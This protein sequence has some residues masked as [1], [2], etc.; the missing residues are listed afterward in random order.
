MAVCTLPGLCAA[1][2]PRLRVIVETDANLLPVVKTDVVGN[3]LHLGFKPFTHIGHVSRLEFRITAPRISA[4]TISGSGDVQ[5]ATPLHGEAMELA[6]RGSGNI[7]A[8][9][10]ATRLLATIGGSGDISAKG[11]TDSLEVTINGSGG[12]SARG[13]RSKSAEVHINGSGDAE[14]F[15]TDTVNIDIA[16]SGSVSYG[17][18]AKAFL[19]ASGSGTV[20]EY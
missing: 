19:H 8:P 20:T 2:E 3:V 7:E 1:Q 17:G 12:F 16:G 6:I 4:I 10:A 11:T 13:L 15:A 5:A 14:I 9:I 18:G